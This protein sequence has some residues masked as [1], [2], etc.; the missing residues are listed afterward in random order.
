[1][2]AGPVS[3]FAP[4]VSFGREECR[5][6][7]IH[8]GEGDTEINRLRYG[9]LF[10]EIERTGREKEQENTSSENSPKMNSEFKKKRNTRKRNRSDM[11]PEELRRLRE[12]ERKAQQSRRDRIRAQKVP[13]FFL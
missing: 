6:T 10:E 8:D 12:R 3:A 7:P 9:V 1:M 5:M 11:S 2:A 4:S 13:N